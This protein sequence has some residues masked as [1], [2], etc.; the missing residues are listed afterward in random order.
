MVTS[1]RT[2][3]E[4]SMFQVKRS[5]FTVDVPLDIKEVGRGTY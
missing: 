3:S 5:V 1:F 4:R 2:T